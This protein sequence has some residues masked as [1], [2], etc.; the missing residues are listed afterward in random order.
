ME[1]TVESSLPAGSAPGAPVAS[2]VIVVYRSA[3]VISDCLRS[4]EPHVRA[5]WLEVVVEDN[6][7]PDD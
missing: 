5:G 1:T 7:S 3:E 6:A 2:A 4:L